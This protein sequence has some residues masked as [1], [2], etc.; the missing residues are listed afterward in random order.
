[1]AAR[2]RR[3]PAIGL[4]FHPESLLTPQGPALLKA[5]AEELAL[6]GAEAPRTRPGRS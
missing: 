4:Q 2:H 3:L 5:L 1:M 6:S